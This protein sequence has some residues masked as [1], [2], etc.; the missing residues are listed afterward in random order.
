MES[1]YDFVC[2]T[3]VHVLGVLFED[4]CIMQGDL[5]ALL[6]AYTS[7]S[8]PA[9]DGENY[10]ALARLRDCRVVSARELHGLFNDTRDGVLV[11]V[12][13]PENACW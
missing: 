2:R 13:A 6:A 5:R 12:A 7:Y 1:F 4:G 11:T 9:Y 3:R 10:Y 8:Y